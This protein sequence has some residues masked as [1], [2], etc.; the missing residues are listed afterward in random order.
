MANAAMPQQP[1]AG[2]PQEKL[3]GPIKVFILAGQSN[4]EGQGV[5]SMDGERDYNGGKGNLVWSM[6][7][8]KSAEKMKCLQ[9]GK[10]EWVVNL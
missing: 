7:N 9:N 1:G 8:S 3:K 10:G 5:V 6:K 2:K 4:M